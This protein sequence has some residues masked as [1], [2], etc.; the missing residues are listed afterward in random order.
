MKTKQ[1]LIQIIRQ[2]AATL[3]AFDTRGDNALWAAAQGTADDMEL[4]LAELEESGDYAIPTTTHAVDLP[5]ILLNAAFTKPR[6]PR[7]PAYKAGALAQLRFRAIGHKPACPY[8]HGTADADA[9]Y[10]GSEEGA[11]LWAFHQLHATPNQDKFK[12]SET[13]Q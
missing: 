4:T 12:T 2:T 6:T 5:E 10:S 3:R 9:W 1:N 7:S 11:K 8:P 13:I